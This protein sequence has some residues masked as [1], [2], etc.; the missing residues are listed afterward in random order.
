MG[1]HLRV[2][3]R[4]GEPLGG[5]EGFLGLDCESIRLHKI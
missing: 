1:R 4:A 5:G 3:A 2:A